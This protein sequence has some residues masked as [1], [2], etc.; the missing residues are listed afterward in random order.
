MDLTQLSRWVR[1]PDETVEQAAWLADLGI[2]SLVEEGRRHWEAGAA[3]G[4][5]EA[6]MG[7]SRIREA[8]ALTDPSGLGAFTIA[9]WVVG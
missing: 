3:T 2:D 7:R 4:G 1:P 8:E 9:R 5:L 6:L